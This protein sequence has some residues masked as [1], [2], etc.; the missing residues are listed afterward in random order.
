MLASVD[1]AMLRALRERCRAMPAQARS[2]AMLQRGDM[3]ASD[4]PLLFLRRCAT[5]SRHFLMFAS[6]RAIIGHA[7]DCRQ[8]REDS[9]S[10][11]ASDFDAAAPQPPRQPPAASCYLF[12]HDFRC[13]AFAAS[14]DAAA[15]M[16]P[17]PLA[18][19]MIADLRHTA[20]AIFSRAAAMP[21]FVY[22]TPSA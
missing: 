7:S 8:L 12:S 11:Y 15:A 17:L 18:Y 10:R 22:A 21:Q 4:A 14:Q 6:F 2:A 3:S 20:T 9:A 5:L 1:G 13:S 19:A 16:P